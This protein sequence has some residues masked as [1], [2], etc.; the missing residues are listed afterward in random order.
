MPDK[1][2]SI[3][4]VE[5]DESLGYMLSDILHAKGW[6]V[7]LAIDGA[8]GLSSFIN[9][10]FDL[11]ILDVMLPYQDGF[12][13]AENIRKY[14]KEVPFIFITAKNMPEDR[15][16]GFKTGADDYVSK[17]FNV[18]ELIYRIEA[19]L[20]RTYGAHENDISTGKLEAS[21]STLD[22]DNQVLIT[23]NDQRSL[24]YKECQ[25]LKIFFNNIDKLVPREVF[26]KAVW[27]DDGFF[28]ARSMDVFISRLRKYLKPDPA[29]RITNVRGIG[30]RL[31]KV[32]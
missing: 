9:N 19:I 2:T 3:L 25:I 12:S 1:N 24:T 21:N 6:Q 31:Q 27:E 17:P 22:I 13:L 23:N 29:L 20:K 16:K 26:F 5:D 30:Y 15:I 18:E 4:L 7:R 14:N 8:K 11:C 28:V 10:S 32:S